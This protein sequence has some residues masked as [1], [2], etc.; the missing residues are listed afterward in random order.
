MV[1]CR[2]ASAMTSLEG[3]L[4]GV[5]SNS[6]S[7]RPKA[8]RP[9]LTMISAWY[10]PISEA[11]TPVVTGFLRAS[12]GVRSPVWPGRRWTRS[13][14][15]AGRFPAPHMPHGNQGAFVHAF[16][17]KT[18]HQVIKVFLAP[19]FRV[20]AAEAHE[21]AP[22]DPFGAPGGGVQPRREAGPLAAGEEGMGGAP[23]RSARDSGGC[24]Q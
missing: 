11:R 17:F 8:F 9:F 20:R 19:F 2:T 10:S 5:V 18:A 1:L 4:Y 7:D 13:T 6:S 22:D 16:R 12:L 23:A 15:R 24:S 3:W 21:D 14:S